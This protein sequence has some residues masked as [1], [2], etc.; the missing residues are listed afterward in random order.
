MKLAIFPVPA[1]DNPIP[2]KLFVQLK[3]VLGTADPE[4]ITDAVGL[5]AQST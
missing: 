2:V 3:I 1:A 4:K 5:L